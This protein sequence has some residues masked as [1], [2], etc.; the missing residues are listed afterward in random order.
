M[1]QRHQRVESLIREEL[2]KLI[3]KELEFP[4]ALMTV[5]GVEA[6]KDLDYAAVKVS[7]IPAEK[8]EEVLKI[9][10]QNQ[11]N[12][13]HLLLKKINIKPMPEIRFKLD[14]GLEKAAEIEKTFIKIEKEQKN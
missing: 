4:G 8:G 9:L 10:I 11:K 13:R 7:V 12:L 6:Q 3:L 14:L 2:D 5:V 1:Y